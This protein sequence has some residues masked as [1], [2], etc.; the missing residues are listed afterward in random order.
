MYST[1]DLHTAG[2][3]LRLV[4]HG[5][6]RIPGATIPE[7]RAW[8]RQHLDPIRR[9]LMLEP[10]GHADMY[11]AYLTE[12]VSDQADYGVIFIHNQGYSDMCGHGIIALGMWLVQQGL[13]VRTQPET[14]V[15]FDSPAGLIEAFVTWDGQRAGRVR[16]RNVPAFIHTR[17]VVVTTPS[18]G[19]IRGDIIFG[20]AFYAYIDADQVPGLEIRER[21]IARLIQLGDEVKQAVS[22]A[23][24]LQHP[25]E[26]DLNRLYGT[27]ICGAPRHPGSTHANCCVFADREVDRS[28]T[29][30]GTSGRVA[31][32]V[33]REQLALEQTIV[34]ESVI[35][36]VFQA[37]AIGTVSVGPWPAVLTEVE[38]EAFVTGYGQWVLDPHDPLSTGFLVRST[39]GD[40]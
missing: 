10:R 25:L 24:P 16:F 38:G 26:L 22:A 31:Q 37:R 2:E 7:K 35:G 29:G 15:G 20:G 6:P 1:V 39:S 17:D 34:N 27:I 40:E 11:G 13:V 18:F 9:L 32:L 23:Y 19:P 14:R 12:P 30:T 36:T 33:L 4:T 21:H 8:C 3:P 28:P 5:L